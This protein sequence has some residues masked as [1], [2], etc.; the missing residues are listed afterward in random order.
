MIKAYSLEAYTQIQHNIQSE[1]T[2]I[3]LLPYYHPSEKFSLHTTD[4][5]LG[6]ESSWLFHLQKLAPSKLSQQPTQN[7]PEPLQTVLLCLC[8]IGLQLWK[9]IFLGV[10]GAYH[11]TLFGIILTILTWTVHTLWKGYG[12]IRKI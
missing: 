4:N 2:C 9:K 8:Y 1:E 10:L 11:F 3:Y 12:K 7:V 6:T 5:G